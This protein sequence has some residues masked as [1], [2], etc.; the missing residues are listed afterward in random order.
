MNACIYCG[1][2]APFSLPDENGKLVPVCSELCARRSRY[3]EPMTR[4]RSRTTGRTHECPQP[5]DEL[6]YW[7]GD[8]YASHGIG[9]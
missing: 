8:P 5:A 9:F 4:K 1:G 2:M 7:S 3:Q 6:C